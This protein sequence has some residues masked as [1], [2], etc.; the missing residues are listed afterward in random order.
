MVWCALLMRAVFPLGCALALALSVFVPVEARAQCKSVYLS[1]CFNS[2]TY[3]PNAG[4]MRFAGVSGT[5]T[6][7]IGQVGFGLV[8]SYQSQPVV[9]RIASP[10]S[11]SEQ[12]IV[13]DQVNGNFTFAYGITNKLELDFVLPVTFVQRGAG[14]GAIS[15]G[16]SLRDTAVRDLRAGFTYALLSRSRVAPSA[17]AERNEDW[18]LA[19]RFIFTAPTGDANDFAGERSAVFVP[20]VAASWTRGR[21]F[22][23]ADLGFRFRPVNEFAG[24]R[25]GTQLTTALG[26]G[27]DVLDRERLALILEGRAYVNLPEQARPTQSSVEL[28]STRNGN[29]IVP[30]EW[31]LGVRSAPVLP[32]DVT[33][34][35][36]G[37][38]PIP[39]G[40]DA[41][42]VPRFRVVLAV[43]YAP[44]ARDT[45]GDGVLDK[46]DQCPTQRGERGGERPGCPAPPPGPEEEKH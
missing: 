3:W 36:G 2:D 37:G 7:G 21:I 5:E 42:T 30:A 41:I 29:H 46:Y 27:V 44:L 25:I 13:D 11:G 15:G 33:F 4:P 14:L 16:T 22:A 19:A 34:L 35:L 45:D 43:V 12:S 1:P 23:G 26:A 28:K 31:F 39:F 6:V 17:S 20:N 32:G 24:A 18:G 10:G 9:L 38:G 8:T 40:D